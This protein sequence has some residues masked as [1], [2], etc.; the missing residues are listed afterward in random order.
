M[1]D[2][3]IKDIS[4]WFRDRGFHIALSQEEGVWWAS[5]TPSSNPA[6]ALPRYG[7]GDSPEA[8]VLRAQERHEQEQ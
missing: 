7:R 5:L 2:D 4:N 6:S 8:A 3:V 1:G